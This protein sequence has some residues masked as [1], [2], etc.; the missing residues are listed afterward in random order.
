MI[1]FYQGLGFVIIEDRIEN[2][3][4]LDRILGLPD[5]IVR[6]VKM[7]ELELLQFTN[8]G[9]KKFRNLNSN[10][11]THIAVNVDDITRYTHNYKVGKTKTGF[12]QD[13]DGNYVEVVNV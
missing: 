4:D 11:L 10:G 5:T 1:K 6:T 7:G 12:I 3:Y 2:G 13:P 8:K 9:D